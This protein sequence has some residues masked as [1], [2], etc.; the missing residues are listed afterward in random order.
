M[1]K[2]QSTDFLIR[3]ELQKSVALAA[4]ASER[5]S[6]V[7]TNAIRKLGIAGRGS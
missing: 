6:G 1:A 4:G 3:F 5:P 7:P 2:A